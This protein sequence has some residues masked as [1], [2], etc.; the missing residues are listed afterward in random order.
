M[1]RTATSHSE[2]RQAIALKGQRFLY[3]RVETA[4]SVVLFV[5]YF[6]ACRPYVDAAR[7]RFLEWR[8]SLRRAA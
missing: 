7:E 6:E 2:T 4:S 5:D 1:I 8:R 3:T